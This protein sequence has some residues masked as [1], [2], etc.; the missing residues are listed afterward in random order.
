VFSLTAAGELSSNGL[1]VSTDVG[2]LAQ[3]FEVSA[4]VLGITRT[5]TVE[6][7]FVY[8]RSAG[9]VSSP[10]QFCQIPSGQVYVLFTGPPGSVPVPQY[11]ANCVSVSLVAVAGK[12]LSHYSVIGLY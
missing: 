6:N 10:A 1:L 8:W 2:V 9:F 3:P 7:G 12:L 4:V 11:P 5:W